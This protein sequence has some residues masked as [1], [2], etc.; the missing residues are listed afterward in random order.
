MEQLLRF[1]KETR[2]QKRRLTNDYSVE[3]LK[4]FVF[5]FKMKQY[6]LDF[7]IFLSYNYEHSDVV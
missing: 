6:Y 5:H 2:F 3:L 7:T 4:L 1:E